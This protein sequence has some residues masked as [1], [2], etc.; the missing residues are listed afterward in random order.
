ME[1]ETGKEYGD[2]SSRKLKVTVNKVT[3]EL[4]VSHL[5]EKIVNEISE[6]E[7]DNS[8]NFGITPGDGNRES[9][10][11][12]LLENLGTGALPTIENSAAIT[13]HLPPGAINVI[14]SLGDLSI[15][16]G[17]GGSRD[18]DDRDGGKPML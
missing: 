17:K 9:G 10:M 11:L 7:I 13:T 4:D 1:T 18:R 3:S 14:E 8:I 12:Q 15:V 5:D 6:V 2:T 16:G